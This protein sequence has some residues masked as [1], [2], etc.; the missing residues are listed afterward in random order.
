M[1]AWGPHQFDSLDL[2]NQLQQLQQYAPE[3]A[4]NFRAPDFTGFVPP[5][6]TVRPQET[7]ALPVSTGV[8]PGTVAATA[9]AI[10]RQ[11][12]SAIPG[13]R[14]DRQLKAA[15]PET[16]AV[17]P[18]ASLPIHQQALG[19]APTAT[20]DGHRTSS[21]RN[22]RHGHIEKYYCH[23]PDCD[24]SQQGSGFRRRDHF[25]QHLQ[26]VHKESTRTER[27]AK[28][29]AVSSS[30]NPSTASQSLPNLPRPQKRKR[31]ED[32]ELD[33]Q[34]EDEPTDG[35]R[36]EVAEERRLR[37]EAEQE[38][39]RLRQKLERYE[40]RIERYEKRIE[41]KDEQLD[42]TRNRLKKYEGEKL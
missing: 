3:P 35:H 19:D 28:P 15:V 6:S 36:E 21:S 38:I 2:E 10:P 37:L 33:P 16:L 13:N 8:I 27:H 20:T 7:I 9:G 32:G 1:D 11:A 39:R 41:R 25:N 40:E 29:A 12:N 5:S 34:R 23:H 17:T 30:P 14:E 31:G 26:R 42:E 18:N 4:T 24:R 22:S